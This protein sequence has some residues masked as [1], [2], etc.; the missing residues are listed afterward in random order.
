MGKILIIGSLNMDM[1][2]N[3]P[4][5]PVIGES[6]AGK[7]F[8]TSPGGKGAN[9]A[10][11]AALLGAEVTMAGCVGGDAF[12]A[13]LRE[14][15]R[16]HG[17][18]VSHIA[19]IDGTPT[20]VAMIVV[21]RGN[22]FIVFD[23]G[24]NSQLTPEMAEALEGEISQSDIVMLQLEVPLATV[25]AAAAMAKKHG[26]RV[27][28]NPAPAVELPDSIIKCVDII[29]PNETEADI[30]TGIKPESDDS[31][32]TAL[33]SLRSRGI[34]QVI[35]TMG[36]KGAMYNAGGEIRI[37]P[38]PDVKVVD[39][40]AAG[41]SFNA[42]VAVALADGKTIDEAVEFAN[43]VGTLTVTKK[44]AQAS[45]PDMRDV[46]EFIKNLQPKNI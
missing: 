28:L 24:A 6:I 41:D 27:L 30:W 15:L 25:E 31:A 8:F 11:A 10:V 35:I 4:R 17:V 21:H 40:T 44:G 5:I 45:L 34:G 20:G 36:S 38:V 12:G 19:E 23:P 43:I 13:Q 33:L 46:E 37:K 22:N 14:N 29:T 32:K 7:G 26:V 1:V 3:T 39:T 2:I 18:D 42:A 16:A 9:Q